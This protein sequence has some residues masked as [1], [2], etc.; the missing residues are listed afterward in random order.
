MKN[1]WFLVILITLQAQANSNLTN[2]NFNCIDLFFSS[3]ETNAQIQSVSQILASLHAIEDTAR[4]TPQLID[5]NK[6]F[7]SEISQ[8]S[9]SGFAAQV[10]QRVNELVASAQKSRLQGASPQMMRI[11]VPS[12]NM[13]HP[14][15][16]Y[17]ESQ[18]KIR[19]GVYENDTLVGK[20]FNDTMTMTVD[21]PDLRLSLT[22]SKMHFSEKLREALAITKRLTG[23]ELKAKF[24]NGTYSGYTEYDNQMFSVAIDYDS[25]SAKDIE[26]LKVFGY[27]IS[28]EVARISIA[29]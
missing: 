29:Q 18:T 14:I 7:K 17:F 9:S 10:D 6:N 4:L 24:S 22:E 26:A 19:F 12:G 2:V 25:E 21:I 15:A 3:S 16:V 27:M 5:P 20:L 11:L 8:N 28:L 23:R 1:F 13:S